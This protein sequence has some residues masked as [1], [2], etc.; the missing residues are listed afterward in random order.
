MVASGITELAAGD[1]LTCFGSEDA[2]ARIAQRLSPPE[3][4]DNG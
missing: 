2:P 4:I 3:R 1:R